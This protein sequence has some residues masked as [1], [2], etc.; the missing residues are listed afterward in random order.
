MNAATRWSV[1]FPMIGLLAVA[2]LTGCATLEPDTG[3]ADKSTEAQRAAVPIPVVDSRP[4]PTQSMQS[5]EASQMEP[6]KA[7]TDVPAMLPE[8]SARVWRSQRAG[9]ALP[10]VDSARLE[11]AIARYQGRQRYF[12]SL[13]RRAR[14]YLHH[15]LERVEAR[16]LPAELA[17]IPMVESAFR[18][19]AYSRS[20]A[21]GLWQFKSLTGMRFGLTQNWWY[22]GR[23]DAIASTEAALDYLAYLHD[24][25]DGD[26]LLAI[27]AYN[28]G[29][30]RV[31]RAVR[32]NEA[33]GRA[34]TFWHLDLPR[35]T[36]QYVPRVLALR[37]ILRQ[38]AHYG[39]TLPAMPEDEALAL[40]EPGG[41]VD[42]ALIA[43]MAGVSMD[44]LYRY[45]AGM[46]RWATPPDGPH[47]LAVPSGQAQA[48]RAALAEHEGAGM[49]WERH[50]V[51]RGE[52][53]SAIGTRYDTTVSAIRDV[54]DIEGD[55]IRAGQDLIVPVASRPDE[56]YTL[57]R[58]NRREAAR[59]QGP[60]G[61]KR[62][63][64][65][66]GAGDTLWA[67][68]RR[69]E[70]SV[71]R[72]AGW[73]DMAP[74]DTLRAGQRLA[75]WV[76]PGTGGRGGP[77]A[78]TQRVSYTVQSG[79]SL[80]EIARRFNVSVEGI[81]RWNALERGALLHPGQRL[82]LRVDVTEQANAH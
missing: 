7:L 20:R 66:V 29:E 27:A 76:Q 8:S 1:C 50:T 24:F 18:P 80:S 62:I 67:L 81:R 36:E 44:T 58:A 2:L 4:G 73:N 26:W 35:E 69:H 43:E 53:L 77:A 19:F 82:E 75:I 21:A 3:Q 59:A 52:T 14:P 33:A 28:A 49:R 32:A 47:R 25:F 5:S 74:G 72:L 31:R 71:E 17:L 46:N 12:E 11:D 23:R 16:G 13:A 40:V 38:P 55:M 51:A 57:S 9:F 48:V 34:S 54:N 10:Q 30:G 15:I 37:N 64:Y 45:N 61:R 68:A 22:D 39:I 60:S 63:D 65:R 70:V 78:G 41:Q 79:D 42:L 6:A 56:A